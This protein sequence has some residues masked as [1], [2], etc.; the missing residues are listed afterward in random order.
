MPVRKGDVE[1]GGD[2]IPAG[3]R[4][5]KPDNTFKSSAKA[6]ATLTLLAFIWGVG[7]RLIVEVF[8]F[9]WNLIPW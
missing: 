8:S 7:G 3:L 9:G 6:I 1:A 5:F 4:R 2:R